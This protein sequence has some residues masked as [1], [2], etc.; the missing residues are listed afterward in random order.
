[1][2][3]VERM[4]PPITT[5]AIG[6]RIS[7]ARPI[8]SATGVIAN[9]VEIVVIRMGRRRTGPAAS[10]AAADTFVLPKAIA[11]PVPKFDTM[12]IR[13]MRPPGDG[14]IEVV[15]GVDGRVTD[16]RVVVSI[17]PAYDSLLLAAAK[18][19]WRYEPA[20]RDGVPVPWKVRVRVAMKRP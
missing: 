14:E 2:S 7:L 6:E 19:D 16:A 13:P 20:L 8:C 1:M 17:A 10:R 11:Q 12:A 18:K 4:R 5:M 9:T 3:S 15:V